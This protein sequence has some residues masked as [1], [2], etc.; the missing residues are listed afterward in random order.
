MI[1]Y[2]VTTLIDKTRETDWLAWMQSQHIRAVMETGCFVSYRFTKVVG[3]DENPGATYN[4]QY[5]L[6]SHA[7]FDLYKREFGPGLQADTQKNF[8]GSYESF[9]TLLEL[10][11]EGT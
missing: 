9:R 2:S 6:P 1:V 11:G 5:I 10:V 3:D 4:V 8:G 7:H